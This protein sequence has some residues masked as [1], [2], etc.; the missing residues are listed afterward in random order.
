MFPY[1]K[2]TSAELADL[3]AAQD[4]P[5]LALEAET[6]FRTGLWWDADFGTWRGTQGA[7]V[8]KGQVV[9]LL[10]QSKERGR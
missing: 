5:T 4:A 2:W 6:R 7:A 1:R 8:A 10:R 3:L 9:Q